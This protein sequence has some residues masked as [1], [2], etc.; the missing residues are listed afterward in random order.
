MYG[1]INVHKHQNSIMK[2]EFCVHEAQRSETWICFSSLECA[3]TRNR[4]CIGIVITD[5]SQFFP[6]IL[7]DLKR[8]YKR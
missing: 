7:E 1:S 5:A 4:L 6:L 2:V 3:R 8:G